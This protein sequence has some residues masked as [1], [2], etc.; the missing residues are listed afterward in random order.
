MGNGISC[1]SIVLDAE[2]GEFLNGIYFGYHVAG[3]IDYIRATSN[4]GQ[5][6][7]KGKLENDMTTTEMTSVHNSRILAFHGYENDRIAAVG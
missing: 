1:S 3:R 2:N 4:K 6:I 5:Q 7:A